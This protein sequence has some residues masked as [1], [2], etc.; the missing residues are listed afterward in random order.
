MKFAHGMSTSCWM[1]SSF[2]LSLSSFTF[3]RR[4]FV[5]SAVGRKQRRRNVNKLW[6]SLFKGSCFMTQKTFGK[7]VPREKPHALY[8]NFLK[9]SFYQMFITNREAWLS[10]SFQYTKIL[11]N[12]KNMIYCKKYCKF[13]LLCS[14]IMTIVLY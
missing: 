8:L 9:I 6:I 10:S 14:K 7:F 5:K 13:Q 4:F 2:L 3:W 12:M 11:R 1:Q